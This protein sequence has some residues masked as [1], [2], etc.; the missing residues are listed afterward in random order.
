MCIAGYSS[1]YKLYWFI[2]FG[3]LCTNSLT[4]VLCVKA[5]LPMEDIEKMAEAC[6]NDIDDDDDENLEDDEDLLV[7]LLINE[8]NI[9][10]YW[11]CCCNCV[12]MSR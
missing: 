9:R 4:T 12:T 11:I 5:P 8:L 1:A 3:C 6:M 10:S 2:S 7:N